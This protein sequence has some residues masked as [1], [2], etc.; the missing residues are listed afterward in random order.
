LQVG[1]G[2]RPVALQVLG[3][4]KAE[5]TRPH[6]GTFGFLEQQSDHVD[7]EGEAERE[8]GGE[9]RDRYRLF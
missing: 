5:L 7:V 2:I 9:K 8:E 3:I 6:L 1:N 4:Q